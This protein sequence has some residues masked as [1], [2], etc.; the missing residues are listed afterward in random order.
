MLHATLLSLNDIEKLIS[1]NEVSVIGADSIFLSF[2][3]KVCV[4]SSNIRH[5]FMSLNNMGQRL[6][7]E[8]MGPPTRILYAGVRGVTANANP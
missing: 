8:F 3:H 5:I 2:R 4:N 7:I 6:D 1:P